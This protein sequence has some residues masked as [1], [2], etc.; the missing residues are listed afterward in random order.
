[1]TA[2]DA[3]ELCLESV[4]GAA[5]PATLYFTPGTKLGPIPVGTEGKWRV[6]A[7]GVM[8]EHA[9]LYYDGTQLFLQSLDEQNPVLVSG[10]EVPTEWVAVDPPCTVEMGDA[11]FAF[12]PAEQD[13]EVGGVS[14]PDSDDDVPT[15]AADETRVVSV[16]DVMA[17]VARPRASS[18]MSI[19]GAGIP[20]PGMPPSVNAPGSHPMGSRTPRAP[21]PPAPPSHPGDLLP[22]PPPSSPFGPPEHHASG[23]PSMPT[24][25][26]VETPGT[27]QTPDSVH[28]APLGSSPSGRYP[29]AR[30]SHPGSYPGGPGPA[31]G[32]GLA[33][34]SYPH[35]ESP[36]GPVSGEAPTAHAGPTPPLNSTSETSN[37]AMRAGS[38][39]PAGPVAGMVASWGKMSFPQKATVIL[40]LPMIASVLVI[41]FD[42]GVQKPP[43]RTAA[44]PTATATATAET[45][46]EP[47]AVAETDE[48]SGGDEGTE[49]NGAGETDG[50]ATD[51]GDGP[52]EGTDEG[53]AK[54]AA[55][56]KPKPRGKKGAATLQRKAADAVAIADYA[57]AVEIYEQLVKKHPGNE[58]Y[59]AALAITQAKAREQNRD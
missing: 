26:S 38:P 23:P 46:S 53:T 16:H 32:P 50:T 58:A 4:D 22:T 59:A 19:T 34:G 8:D 17:S 20:A 13:V 45:T 18:G 14:D 10:Y 25:H 24:P 12:G 56:P 55:A 43:P 35:A 5:Q 33:S 36:G 29:A 42:I 44:A 48:P 27:V 11:Q 57:R 41:F 9:L 52:N 2:A 15:E 3:I 40:F 47:V 51:G 31:S 37:M 7:Q 28:T 1:M 54:T 6:K 21:V 39:P 30:G 49:P